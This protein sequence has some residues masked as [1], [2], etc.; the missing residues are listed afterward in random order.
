MR[1]FTWQFSSSVTLPS[2]IPI[3]LYAEL[4]QF[5]IVELNPQ[6]LIDKTP[7]VHSFINKSEVYSV[8]WGKLK[9]SETT[10]TMT[11]YRSVCQEK[12]EN[13]QINWEE[14]MWWFSL[15]LTDHSLIAAV[16]EESPQSIVAV[17][18]VLRVFFILKPFKSVGGAIWSADITS[19]SLEFYILFFLY[20]LFVFDHKY[21]SRKSFF[22]QPLEI[23]LLVGKFYT[24]CS[25]EVAFFSHF[26]RDE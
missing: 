20:T 7:N 2:H 14:S 16:Y 4:A 5:A 24:F 21:N 25:L 22:A 10:Y 6:L 3:S 26:C 17:C 18:W 15:L 1:N 13:E 23:I 9:K 12:K 11:R 19:S 8:S